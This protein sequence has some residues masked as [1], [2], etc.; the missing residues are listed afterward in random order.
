M[1]RFDSFHDAFHDVLDNLLEI[2]ASAGVSSSRSIGS[3][4]SGNV[5]GTRELLAHS[6]IISNPTDRLLPCR[7]TD[8]RSAIANFFWTMAG[9]GDPEAIIHYNP[10]GKVF[11]EDS[12]L[13]C[14]IP[15]RMSNGLYRSQ[16]VDAVELLRRDS[17]SR[18]A[19]VTFTRA[20]DIIEDALDFPCPTSIHFM[21]RGNKLV[22][23]VNMRSQSAFGVMP[24]DV[25]L[26]TMIQEAMA[27]ELGV[28]VGDYI[29]ISN[30]IHIYEDEVE[31]ALRL[32]GCED[33]STAMES[34]MWPTPIYNT[35][36]LEAEESIR[37]NNVFEKTGLFYWDSL[38]FEL[39]AQ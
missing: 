1:K 11:L 36:L 17:A 25:F 7:G 31:R 26:F 28:E 34:M 12:E 37:K 32:S 27:L 38:L 10:K 6:F 20:D 39:L 23:I 22:A 29:H 21:I 13:K 30:S 9:I 33:R 19:L 4:F 16:L 24:Y 5:R 18:R 2:P 14:A 8:I 3:Q 15:A 35:G